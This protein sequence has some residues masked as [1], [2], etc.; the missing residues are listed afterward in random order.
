MT[1]TSRAINDEPEDEE[2]T[3]AAAAP[4]GEWRP[5]DSVGMDDA[6]GP[7]EIPDWVKEGNRQEDYDIPDVGDIS[8][9]KPMERGGDFIEPAKGVR[10]LIKKIELDRYTPKDR[11]AWKSIKFNVHLQIVDGITY[12][13]Q[14]KPMYKGKMFF[15][16]FYVAVNRAVDEGGTPFY[17]FSV[18]SSGKATTWW[19]PSGGAWGEYKEF[20]VA[21]GFDPAKPP[22]NNKA[23]QDSL[24]ARTI[25]YDV[26]KVPK[27]EYDK[28]LGKSVKL[29]GEYDNALTHARTDK[30]GNSA[31]A[32]PA[33]PAAVAEADTADWD[34]P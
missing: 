10:M 5:G 34:K 4:A 24:I 18:N 27:E 8:Q 9:A 21:L 12:R 11:G 6:I 17:D 29:K 28:T 3:G 25:I 30:G 20:L 26:D 22:K 16:R 15:H 14:A 33:T 19:E 23:F 2:V 1:M 31:T 32:T 7:D 13:G